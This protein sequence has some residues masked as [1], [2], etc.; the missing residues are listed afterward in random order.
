MVRFPLVERGSVYFELDG[1]AEAGIWSFAVALAAAKPNIQLS[2]SAYAELSADTTVT[3]STWTSVHGRLASPLDGPVIIYARVTDGELP[4][5]GARV[6]VQIRKPQGEIVKLQLGDEGTGYPDITA[7]DGIYSGYLTSFSSVAGYYSLE[8]VAEDGAGSARIPTPSAAMAEDCCGSVYP[9]VSSIPTPSFRRVVMGSSFY[10]TQGVQFFIRNGLPRIEDIFPPSRITDLR[11]EPGKGSE[12]LQVV[13]GWTAPGGNFNQGTADRYQIR[14]YTNRADATNSSRSGVLVHEGSVPRPGP[15]GSVEQCAVTLPLANQIF[16]Y[17]VVAVDAADNHGPLSNLVPVMT[18]ELVLEAQASSTKNLTGIALHP[19]VLEVFEDNLMVYIIAGC[20][21]GIILIILIVILISLRIS[22]TRNAVSKK[23][24]RDQYITE[25]SSPT[26]IHSSS[27]LPGILKDSNLSVLPPG[28]T[29]KCSDFSLDYAVYKT[30]GSGMPAG[31]R[32]D[33]SWAILPTYSNSAFKKS[34]DTLVD[35][36]YYRA[37]EQ[38]DNVSEFYRPCTDYVTYQNLG[39]KEGV[40]SAGGG[41]VS[42]N[43]TGTTSSTDC[44]N[45]E[46]CSDKALPHFGQQD[47]GGGKDASRNAASEF[48]SLIVTGESWRGGEAGKLS[49]SGP[50]SLQGLSEYDIQEKRRRR[51]SFV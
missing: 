11:V 18:R 30:G 9:V 24:R 28:S 2:V 47:G 4:V 32:D 21:T 16:W 27:N 1:L 22:K 7:G 34:S 51:E 36:G 10:L 6:T 15:A 40:V 38:V 5:S 19:S 43:G 29:G 37:G 42:D 44:E 14:A 48:H 39:L 33:I 45:S 17:G 26:L 3:V 13:L 8:V 46:T 41:D 50:L 20:V 35:S 12:G 23:P 25:I 31:N 49:V